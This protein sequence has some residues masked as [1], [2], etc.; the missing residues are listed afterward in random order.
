MRVENLKSNRS[1]RAVPNQYI[2]QGN[3]GEIYFQSYKSIIAM[4]YK[5]KTYL[6]KN[7]W[8]YSRTTGKYRN[9]FLGENSKET[10]AKIA[11]GEYLLIDL[12]IDNPENILLN[13]LKT[14]EG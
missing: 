8:D 7:Y 11:S 5:G 2:L 9:Q 1:N 3:N 14:Y 6:D 4:K 10:K 12:N 13:I